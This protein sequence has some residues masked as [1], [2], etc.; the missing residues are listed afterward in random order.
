MFRYS[1]DKD[2]FLTNMR[3]LCDL[4]KG[5]FHMLKTKCLEYCRYI[6]LIGCLEFISVFVWTASKVTSNVVKIGYTI[7]R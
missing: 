1:F 6:L 2:R 5:M 4:A 7:I 3:Y